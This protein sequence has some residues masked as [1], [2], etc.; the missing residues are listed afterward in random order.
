MG[1]NRNKARP[2]QGRTRKSKY[3]VSAPHILTASFSANVVG[4]KNFLAS[5]NVVEVT[6]ERRR[7]ELIEWLDK[8]P[9][10]EEPCAPA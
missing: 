9:R 5:L 3:Q 4:N 10:Y 6:V 1:R 2:G 8:S 7:P